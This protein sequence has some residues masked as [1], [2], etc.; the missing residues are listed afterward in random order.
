MSFRGVEVIAETYIV[1][2]PTIISRY[3]PPMS[4]LLEMTGDLQSRR[5]G[6]S[7]RREAVSRRG[8]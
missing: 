5:V 2:C 7:E 4:D 3:S 8:F 6:I 1:S